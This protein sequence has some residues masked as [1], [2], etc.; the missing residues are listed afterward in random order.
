MLT[1]L[2]SVKKA[3]IF[4]SSPIAAYVLF[5]YAHTHLPGIIICPYVFITADTEYKIFSY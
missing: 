1:F 4:T 5:F 3:L 2:V